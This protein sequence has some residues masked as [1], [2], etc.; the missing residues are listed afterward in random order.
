MPGIGEGGDLRLAVLSAASL[1]EDVVVGAELNGGSRYSRSTLASGNSL[2]SR[3]QQRL[4]PKRS[5][6]MEESV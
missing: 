5:R 4:S 1:E 2:V 3:S 6:F